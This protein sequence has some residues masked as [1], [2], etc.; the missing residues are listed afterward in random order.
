MKCENGDS[1]ILHVCELTVMALEVEEVKA[2][3]TAVTT[4]DRLFSNVTSD[5]VLDRL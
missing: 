1:V 5:K 2:W 3:E 4:R